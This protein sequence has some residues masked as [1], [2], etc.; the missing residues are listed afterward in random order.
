MYILYYYPASSRAVPDMT[1]YFT[2]PITVM[3]S[4]PGFFGFGYVRFFKQEHPAFFYMNSRKLVNSD[5][6]NINPKKQF[7]ILVCVM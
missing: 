6:N 3:V 2:F 1:V 4:S 5:E 7:P